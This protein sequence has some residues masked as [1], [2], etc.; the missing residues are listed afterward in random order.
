MKGVMNKQLDLEQLH[1]LNNEYITI[2]DS[3]LKAE[4]LRDVKSIFSVSQT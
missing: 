4:D 2:E 1:S 3:H